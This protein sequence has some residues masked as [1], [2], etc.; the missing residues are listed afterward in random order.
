MATMKLFSLLSVCGLA[1]VGS[2]RAAEPAPVPPLE[3]F[4]RPAAFSEI[5][6]SPSGTKVAALSKWKEHDNL[7]VIDLKTKKPS[8]LTGLDTQ[9]V[10]QVTWIGDDRLIFT[11]RED[12][13]GTGGL[14]AI[15][16]DGK[17]SRAL[18]PSVMQQASRGVRAARWTDFLDFYGDSTEEILVASNERR[19]VDPDVYRMSVR[20]GLKQMVARNPG[21]VQAWVADGKGVVRAGFGE[22]GRETF[23]VYREDAKSPWREVYHLDVLKG[24]IEPLAFDQ[25]NRLLYVRSSVDRATAAICLFDPAKG[26]IVRELYADPVYDAGEVHLDPRDRSLLG[27]DLEAE[28]ERYVWT[29]PAMAK[30]QALLDQELPQT[31]NRISN[32]SLDRVWA[33]ILAKSDRAP[34]TYFLFNTRELTL[35]KL[36]EG[37]PWLKASQLGEMR[38]I[39]YTAHDGLTI[40]GYLTI[41]PGVEPKDLPLIVNPHGGP[42]ARDSW[43]YNDEVHFLAS[44]GYAVLQVNFRGSVGYGRKFKEAGYGQWGL[45]MQDDITDGV[46]WAVSQGIADPNRVAI[47]GASYGGYAAMA[48]M[49]FTPELYRCGVN[50]VGVTDIALLLKTLPKTWE[51]TR[52]QVELMTGN[53]K[54]DREQIEAASVTKHADQIRAPVFFAYGEQD[55]R[56]D[57]RHATKLATQLRHNGVPVTWMTRA[58]EGHGYRHWDNKVAFYTELERF[59]AEYTKPV[60]QIGESKVIEMPAVLPEKR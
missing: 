20:T 25:E 49:A 2:A 28:K 48:G 55:D 21:D 1:M 8:Q 38:P 17:N 36:I 39:T 54:K 51:S 26:E 60:G 41:P 18:A 9:D 34:G 15:D 35:E 53:A 19:D 23:V 13:Y 52:A 27:Y 12:G 16:A 4:F 46:K 57:M 5:K 14:F 6:L 30:I 58:N 7:Y 31:L 29:D 59:L 45:K 24:S 44:R 37:K 32:F 42:W 56:I 43:G 10:V 11:C 22:R 33:V 3:D 47:Y 40:H 50:Y